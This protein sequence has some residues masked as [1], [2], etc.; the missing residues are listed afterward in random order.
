MIV[1]FDPK[2]IGEASERHYISG[3]L[4]EEFWRIELKK[5]LNELSETQV[6]KLKQF[7]GLQYYLDKG[8]II[9]RDEPETSYGRTVELEQLYESQGY[10]AISK[11]ATEY[12][13]AKPST[14]WRDAI[15]LIVKYEESLATGES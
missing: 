11:I 5:G 13:I 14:G 4:D 10:T 8:A 12:G 9:F 1:E 2:K 6:Q 15:P 3:Y 7:D